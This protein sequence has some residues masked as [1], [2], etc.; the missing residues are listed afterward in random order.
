MDM[1]RLIGYLLLLALAPAAHAQT[2]VEASAAAQKLDRDALIKR[3]LAGDRGEIT[4]MEPSSIEGKGVIIGYSSGAVVHCYGDEEC[5]VFDGTPRS[6]LV[7]GVTA[8]AVSQRDN[9]EIVWVAYPHG[10]LYRCVDYQCRDILPEVGS[11][12]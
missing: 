5:R 9:R 4:V 11:S 8:I 1:Y 10:I 2:P 6:T 12:R 3:A 7:G